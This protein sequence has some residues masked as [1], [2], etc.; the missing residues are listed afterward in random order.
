V[1]ESLVLRNSGSVCSDGDFAAMD[2]VLKMEESL[3]RRDTRQLH[4]VLILIYFYL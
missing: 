2:N 4:G 3:L 1:T